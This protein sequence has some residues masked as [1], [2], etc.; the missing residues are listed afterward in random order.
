MEPRKKP[1]V[2]RAKEQERE[3]NWHLAGPGRLFGTHFSE[4]KARPAC[5]EAVLLT[6]C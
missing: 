5:P 4:G 1:A 2:V 3:G 6:S